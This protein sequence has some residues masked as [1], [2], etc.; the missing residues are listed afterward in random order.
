VAGPERHDLP[1]DKRTRLFGYGLTFSALLI[2]VG[3]EARTGL[4]CAGLL[5]LLMMRTVKYRWCMRWRWGG[6]A[7]GEAAAAQ[8]LFGA[9]G[10]DR[11]Q[12]GRR[13]ASTRI[14][15][16][17]WTLGYVA[18][19]PFGGGFDSFRG[20]KLLIKTID[21]DNRGSASQTTTN[22]VVDQGR[23]FTRPISRCWANRAGRAVPVADPAT[24]RHRAA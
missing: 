20:N 22:Q 7:A 13:I 21:S 14:A 4:L 8:Q 16:W 15:V 18:E 11:E 6:G 5:A 3:T 2:P 9:H 12:P 23:A 17:K 1:A 10:H 19:H 24:Q